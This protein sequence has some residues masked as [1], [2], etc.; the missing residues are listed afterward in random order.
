MQTARGSRRGPFA[1]GSVSR[2][3]HLGASR[4]L[5]P[6]LFKSQLFLHFAE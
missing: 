6:F 5:F 3:L 2:S 1:F 4:N